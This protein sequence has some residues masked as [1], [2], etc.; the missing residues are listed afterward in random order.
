MLSWAEETVARPPLQSLTL[1]ISLCLAFSIVACMSF[2]GEQRSG[3]LF[4]PHRTKGKL[5]RSAFAQQRQKEGEGKEITNENSDREYE[6]YRRT[7]RGR[8]GVSMKNNSIIVIGMEERKEVPCLSESAHGRS[9]E[10]DRSLHRDRGG[11]LA[12]LLVV[13]RRVEL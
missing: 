9:T 3:A 10:R 2:H 6:S 11:K 7:E 13:V 1:W 12:P 5:I 4:V 8:K